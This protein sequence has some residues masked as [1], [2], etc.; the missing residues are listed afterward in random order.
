MIFSVTPTDFIEECVRQTKLINVELSKFRQAKIDRGKSFSINLLI[1]ECE[2]QLRKLHLY[3]DLAGRFPNE[4]AI[5]ENDL[6]IFEKV[7]PLRYK[8]LVE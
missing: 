6:W 4:I 8:E 1:S 2:T 3:I 7:A 5:E